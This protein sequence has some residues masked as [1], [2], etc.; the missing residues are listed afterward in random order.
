MQSRNHLGSWPI[1]FCGGGG[2]GT[3]K[4]SWNSSKGKTYYSKREHAF[5]H[6]ELWMQWLRILCLNSENLDR[7]ALSGGAIVLEDLYLKLRSYSFPNSVYWQGSYRQNWMDSMQKKKDPAKFS[8]RFVQ[9]FSNSF[10]VIAFE[11]YTAV[12]SKAY[13]KAL[14]KFKQINSERFSLSSFIQRLSSD[15]TPAPESCHSCSL[16]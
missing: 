1:A 13:P 12:R 16:K 14:S 15:M 3:T 6:C 5:I 9:N 7:G 11:T 8:I 2:G 4:K 10:G